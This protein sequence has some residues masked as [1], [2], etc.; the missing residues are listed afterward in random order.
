[1]CFPVLTLFP[2]FVLWVPS[3]QSMA[4]QSSPLSCCGCSSIY[5]LIEQLAI[6]TNKCSIN[7][8]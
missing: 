3:R 8:F 5:V 6:D 4:K 7:K 2:G 1:M